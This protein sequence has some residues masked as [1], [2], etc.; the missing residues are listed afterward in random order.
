VI[1]TP[2]DSLLASTLYQ[3][4]KRLFI[5]LLCTVQYKHIVLQL[6]PCCCLQQF[7]HILWMP[8]QSMQQQQ[9]L[10]KNLDHSKPSLHT[11]PTDKSLRFKAICAYKSK[12]QIS[13]VQSHL[14]IQ[15]VQLTNVSTWKPSLHTRSPTY[16]LSIASASD[17]SSRISGSH[18]IAKC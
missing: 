6:D 2:L 1:H 7:S 12:L 3:L 10:L 8:W 16:I 18:Y 11:S 14:C 5:G 15:D 13:G 4:L 17:S 9:S